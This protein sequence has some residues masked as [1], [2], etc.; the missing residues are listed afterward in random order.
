MAPPGLDLLPA[1]PEAEMTL[2]PSPVRR[3]RQIA[4]R[5][6]GNP[7]GVGIEKQEHAFAAAEEDMSALRL[8]DADQ[9]ENLTVEGFRP[10]EIVD[11]KGGF[12]DGGGCHC[13]SVTR[14]PSAAG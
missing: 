12:E 7:G 14:S 9:P 10:I 5:R 6:R 8:G 13:V 11:I 3:N 1:S 2:P 4:V